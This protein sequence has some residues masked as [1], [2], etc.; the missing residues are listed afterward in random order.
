MNQLEQSGYCAHGGH[1]LDGGIWRMIN[2]EWY[3]VSINL[4]KKTG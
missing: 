3:V 4:E 1:Y 2:V